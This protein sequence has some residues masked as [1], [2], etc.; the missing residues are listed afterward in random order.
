MCKT[1]TLYKKSSFWACIKQSTITPCNNYTDTAT[2]NIEYTMI[3]NPILCNPTDFNWFYKICATVSRYILWNSKCEYK[4]FKS[5]KDSENKHPWN[6][7][8]T[9]PKDIIPH[10]NNVVHFEN[11]HSALTAI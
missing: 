3:W 2:A 8:Q 10:E 6:D 11:I 1:F 9:F 4:H 7:E 5:K